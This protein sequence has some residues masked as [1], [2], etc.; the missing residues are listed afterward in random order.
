MFVIPRHV[1]HTFAYHEDTTLVSLY[2]NGV[3]LSPTEKD[4]WTE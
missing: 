4:I 3:E 1:F 2:S